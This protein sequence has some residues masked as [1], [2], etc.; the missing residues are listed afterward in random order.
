MKLYASIVP[1]P[2]IVTIYMA[3][4]VSELSQMQVNL[5]GGDGQ[6]PALERVDS[7]F[8]CE[9]AAVCEYLDEC[10]PEPPLVA[11]TAE[12]RVNTRRRKHRIDL[13]VCGLLTNSLRYVEGLPLFAPRI[14]ILPE[15]AEWLKSVAQDGLQWL[16]PLIA[17]HDFIVGN[18]LSVAD[19][20]LF[21]FFDFGTTD[22]QPIGRDLAN[23][24]RWYDRMTALP[25]ARPH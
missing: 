4:K 25:S 15:A 24:P 9:I 19:I 20:L 13:K 11:A 3:E 6:T 22:G 2:R 21:A 14:R 10:D 1:N 18:R 17:G 12:K 16:D 23:V 5:R 8:L 7:S